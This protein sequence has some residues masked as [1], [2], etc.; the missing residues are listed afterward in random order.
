MSTFRSLNPA[1]P[2][3]SDI[4]IAQS[5]EPLE[6]TKIAESVGILDDELE[7][8][9]KHKAKVFLKNLFPGDH[10]GSAGRENS[11]FSIHI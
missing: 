7:A 9:G 6:I 1:T 5:I 2:V 11:F 3:P 10:P 4:E 8:Y